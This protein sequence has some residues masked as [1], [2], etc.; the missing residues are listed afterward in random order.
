MVDENPG[1]TS[2]KPDYAP[3]QVVIDLA[4]LERRIKID[5]LNA[6]YQNV[7]PSKIRSGNMNVMPLLPKN[8]KNIPLND[9]TKLKTVI[10]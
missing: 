4:G 9:Q 6:T 7:L 1:L 8:M 2:S 10:Q 3:D 5:M